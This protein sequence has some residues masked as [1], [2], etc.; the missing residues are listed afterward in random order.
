MK[1]SEG[2]L[3][4]T[5]L[6]VCIIASRFNELITSKL[7]EGAKD[8]LLRHEVSHQ[9][10]EIIWVPGAWELPLVAQE[11]ALSGRFDGIIALG[12]VIRGDTPH[13]EYVSSEMA[14]GLA[15]VGL[16]H[17]TPISFGV[18]TCDTLEQA[19]LRAGSKA[20]NKGAESALAFIET[21]NLL[22]VL[23]TGKEQED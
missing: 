11:A 6:K 19:L 15:T 22:K 20:G 1:I 3:I 2:K 12:A 4:G 21:A 23:R 9:N 17:R 13:F 18:L 10:I 7:I 14:K 16:S 8:I 5:G